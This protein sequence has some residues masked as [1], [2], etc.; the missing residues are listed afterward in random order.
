MAAS[1]HAKMGVGS[2][3]DY[4]MEERGN[5]VRYLRSPHSNFFSLGFT[6][7]SLTKWVGMATQVLCDFTLSSLLLSFCS[8]L[9]T[10]L[11]HSLQRGYAIYPMVLRILKHK[12]NPRSQKLK[13]VEGYCRWPTLRNSKTKILGGFCL[14]SFTF[15]PSSHHMNHRHTA[16]KEQNRTHGS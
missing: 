7:R 11:N 1:L 4:S 13:S 6:D 12:S 9:I 2:S 14:L 5:A 16:T 3:F 10:E 8:L 15:H